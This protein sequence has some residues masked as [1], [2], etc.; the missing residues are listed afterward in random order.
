MKRPISHR[1]LFGLIAFASLAFLTALLYQDALSFGYVWDDTL[2]FVEKISLL[3]EPLSWG[4][5]VEP[6]LPGTTYM[7]PLV[8]LTFYIEFAVFGQTP[9]VSHLI[10]IF[11]LFLN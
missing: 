3:N 4:L 8:F 10:N 11:L 2:L 5:L 6:V 1:S 7:R 9:E